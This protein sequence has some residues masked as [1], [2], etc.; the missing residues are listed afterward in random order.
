ML[1]I[2]FI[3]RNCVC[4]LVFLDYAL[5][6]VFVLP[7]LS[8]LRTVTRSLSTTN[9]FSYDILHNNNNNNNNNNLPCGGGLEHHRSPKRRRRRRK[10]N[11]MPRVYLGHLI[12]RGHK[13]R[14]LV[15][16]V[17]VLE[18]KLTTLFGKKIVAKIQR[19]KNRM[20]YFN[21]NLVDLPR[22][23]TLSRQTAHGWR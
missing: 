3:M 5:S 13:Y 17:R 22:K 19:S 11:P 7:K 1:P 20:V 23:A 15:L 16:E 9:K 8:G 18:A 6:S 12:T 14:D 4:P 21:I 2:L 10:A